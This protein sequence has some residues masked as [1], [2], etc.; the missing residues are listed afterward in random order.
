MVPKKNHNQ[1]AQFAS[2][3]KVA[4]NAKV[5][6]AITP[7]WRS[8]KTH[9]RFS[10]LL[11]FIKFLF[12]YNLLTNYYQLILG[13]SWAD[14][15]TIPQVHGNLTK[16]HRVQLPIL[17]QLTGPNAGAYSNEAD[18]FEDNFQCTFFGGDDRYSRLSEIKAKYDPTDL[19]IVKTGVGSERWDDDGFCRVY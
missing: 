4:E 2:L 5:S 9:V 3:G 7:A 10:H 13:N 19:F 12:I 11:I 8:A 1:F 6:N 15:A 18:T 14:S 16:F 17:E